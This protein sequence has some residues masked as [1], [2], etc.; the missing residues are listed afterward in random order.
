VVR[1]PPKK[2]KR[3]WIRRA[4]WCSTCL[5]VLTLLT[6]WAAV[7]RKPS[8]YRP[9][10][11]DEDRLA[12]ARRDSA[13]AADSFGDRLVAGVPFEVILKDE[14]LTA[15]LTAAPSLWPD[16]ARNWPPE[17]TAPA[18]RFQ[19]GQA[20]IGGHI[21]SNGWRMILGASLHASV[22]ADPKALTFRLNG[23]YGGSLPLPG[24]LVERVAGFAPVS[25][26]GDS[27][28]DVPTL[29]ELLAGWPIQNRFVWPNGKRAFRIADIQ[30]QDG[31]ARI[32]IEPL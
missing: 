18:I 8:W 15:W 25:G 32:A 22:A 9:V 31:A 10:N 2:S 17:L 21:E 12:Q 6:I 23:I 29:Q 24:A 14:D 16:L 26:A 30:F 5:S 28:A 19:P 1:P 11:L 27:E 4:G 13:E 20:R 3:K 7:Q